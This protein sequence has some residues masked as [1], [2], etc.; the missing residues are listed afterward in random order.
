MVK[1][2]MRIDQWTQQVKQLKRQTEQHAIQ[3]LDRQEQAWKSL[4]A[5]TEALSP[6]HALKRGYA[7][8]R[9]QAGTLLTSK[10]QTTKNEPFTVIFAD[11]TAQAVWKDTKEEGQCPQN[12]N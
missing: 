3:A 7:I 5:R 1:L 9:D 6:Q 11:G 12:S 8:L 4:V 2:E 10:Q